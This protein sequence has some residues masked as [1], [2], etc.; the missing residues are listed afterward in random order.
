MGKLILIDDNRYNQRE[1]YNASFVDNDEFDCLFHIER[2]NGRDDFSFLDNAS[3]IMY[4]DSLEDFENGIFIPDSHKAKDIIEQHLFSKDIPYVCFSDGHPINATWNES[5]PMVISQIKK[6]EFYSHLYDFLADYESTQSV[7]LLILAYGKNYKE[8]LMK[9]WH[10]ELISKIKQNEI[11]SVISLD[12]IDGPCLSKFIE[13]AQPRIG[14]T[15]QELMGRIEDG[16]LT[17]GQYI[18]N[19]NNIISSVLKYG[20]NICT[21]E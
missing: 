12:R 21:W 5:N 3:C 8:N 17:T 15:Y 9:K 19:I 14:V 16:E 20:K 7:N 2:L 11:N 1:I 13:G 4:H 18:T 10:Q 6:S